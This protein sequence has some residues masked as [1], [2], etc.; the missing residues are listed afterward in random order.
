M[1]ECANCNL[2][3]PE[4]NLPIEIEYI[5]TGRDRFTYNK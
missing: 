5:I 1:I 2:T 3:V 4:E